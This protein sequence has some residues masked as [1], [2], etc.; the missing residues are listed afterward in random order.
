VKVPS[1]GICAWYL[2]LLCVVMLQAIDF[3]KTAKTNPKHSSRVMNTSKADL[4][5]SV[6][7]IGKFEECMFIN[8]SGERL[9]SVIECR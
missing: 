8:E 6:K 2:I 9:G 1:F 3:L 4:K 7:R 5:L